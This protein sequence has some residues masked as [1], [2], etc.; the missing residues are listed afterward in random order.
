MDVRWRY[1][2]SVML[3]LGDR[4]L[5]ASQWTLSG[6]RLVCHCRA[7]ESCHGDTLI[8]EFKRSLP[9]AY[10]RFRDRGVPPDPRILSFM[11]RLREEPESE[12]GSSPDEGVPPKMSGHCGKGQPMK[13]GVGYTQRDFC[14]GQSLASP[15]RWP[16]GSRVYPSSRSWASVADCFVRFTNH[17]GT[18]Q[19]LVSLAMGKIDSCP[20]PPD[21]V[22]HLKESVIVRL[23]VSVIRS[24]EDLVIAQTSPLITSS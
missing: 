11:A 15:G 7:T 20:F 23:L 10:D 9:R 3:L 5:Y 1:R 21:D 8:E 6:S 19:L 24:R 2:V 14:D 16:P 22:A 18:E 12:E 17:H 4:A 13:V